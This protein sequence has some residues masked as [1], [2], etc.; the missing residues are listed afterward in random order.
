MPT[1]KNENQQME[2]LDQFLT[3]TTQD[4][5]EI[6]DTLKQKPVSNSSLSYISVPIEILPAASFYK[7]GTLI[8]IRSANVAEV[9]AYSVVDENNYIDITEKMNELLSA[10]VRFIHPNGTIGSYKNL[11]D[12]DRFFL[13][14]M[15]KE[16]TFQKG[17][18]LAKDYKCEECKHEFKISFR[19][20]P[21]VDQP[22]TFVNYERPEEIENYYDSN[23]KCYIITINNSEWKIA[24]PSIGLQEIFYNNIKTKV[25]EKKNPNISLLKILPYLLYDRDKITDAGIEAKEK[26]FKNMDMETFQILNQ[27]VD[28]LKFGIKE[29]KAICPNCSQEVYAPMDFQKYGAASLF[30][31]PDYFDDFIKK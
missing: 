2:Y 20:T 17:N 14:F 9:Q 22:R 27:F 31:I 29:L 16:L 11:K 13:I 5:K 10:C 6:K 21:G 25:G 28:R 8:K 30:V 23:E 26:E 7:K 24:I 19:A 1:K 4:I 15:V 3:E 12:A 18:T